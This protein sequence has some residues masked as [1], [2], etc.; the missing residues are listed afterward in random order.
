MTIF[1]RMEDD[2][3]PARDHAKTEGPP[4][5]NPSSVWAKIAA[6]KTDVPPVGRLLTDDA[7]MPELQRRLLFLL[8]KQAP[9]P[10][11]L[12]DISN[13]LEEMPSWCH[14]HLALLMARGLVVK[15]SRGLYECQASPPA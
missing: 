7:E 12:R 1:S 2:C 11:Q 15:P 9:R 10:M 6:M 3:V 13:A 14:H 8:R 5:M 4:V